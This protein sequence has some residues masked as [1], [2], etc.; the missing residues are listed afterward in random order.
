MLTT[1]Y[2]TRSVSSNTYVSKGQ[3]SPYTT[4]TI[5][6]NALNLR[7]LKADYTIYFNDLQINNKFLLYRTKI[8]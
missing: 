6:T 8:D 7:F 1:Y 5:I 3:L 4:G 2:D